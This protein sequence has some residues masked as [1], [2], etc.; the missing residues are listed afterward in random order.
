MQISHNCNDTEIETNP[1]LLSLQI[2][3][4]ADEQRQ[5]EFLD[6]FGRQLA[7]LRQILPRLFTPAA[8]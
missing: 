6:L 7:N 4:C 2:D 3:Y 5:R 8:T 1:A